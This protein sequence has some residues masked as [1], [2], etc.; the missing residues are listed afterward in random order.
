MLT[1][2]VSDVDIQLRRRYSQSPKPCRLQ[3]LIPNHQF[4]F[5]WIYLLLLTWL[6]IRSSCP[7]S[8]QWASQGLHF[9][10][11]NPISLAGTSRWPGEGRNPEH[12]NWSLGFLR[13]PFLDHSNIHTTYSSILHNSPMA[14][15]NVVLIHHPI[16]IWL[17]KFKF[18]WTICEVEW[19]FS[20][21]IHKLVENLM[22]QT[23]LIVE[24]SGSAICL[25]L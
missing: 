13:E 22:G 11:L 10:G 25:I 15:S 24:R 17:K 5:C 14:I 16:M 20:V 8:H 1:N 23:S 3:K 4:S 19:L 9:A 2:R 12:I 21:L 7:H 6:T 18:H